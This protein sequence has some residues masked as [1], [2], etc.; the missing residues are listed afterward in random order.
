MADRN[1]M[2]GHND[3]AYLADAFG[4][5]IAAQIAATG[6]SEPSASELQEA[7]DAARAGD[8]RALVASKGEVSSLDQQVAEKLERAAAAALRRQPHDRR[9]RLNRCSMRS[10]TTSIAS[11][12]P[13]PPG[14]SSVRRSS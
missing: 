6:E 2:A 5:K 4:F 11:P 1:V 8:V 3:F 9:R 7:V 10:P 12:T 14:A 13:S